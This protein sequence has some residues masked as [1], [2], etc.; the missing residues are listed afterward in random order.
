M[1]LPTLQYE[2]TAVR[3]A[4]IILQ[5]LKTVAAHV[6]TKLPE[7]ERRLMG[8]VVDEFAS[9]AFPQF[10]EFLSK[11]RGAG[12]AL[13]LSHQSL[14]GDLEKAGE[15]FFAQV[16]ANTNVKLCMRQDNPDDAEGGVR[17]DRGHVHDV[18]RDSADAGR[19][20]G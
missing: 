5:D 7:S 6:Q 8:V 2:E 17:S 16:V 10:A 3:L 14:R 1:G 19:P 13:L 12:M 11:A 9:F 4:R 18:E 15:A 20:V